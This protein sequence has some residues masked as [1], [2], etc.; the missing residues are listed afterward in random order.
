MSLTFTDMGMGEIAILN[1]TPCAN[2]DCI[3]VA[4]KPGAPL[5]SVGIFRANNTFEWLLEDLE[6]TGKDAEGAA[7]VR[8][9]PDG[10][11]QL[12][13]ISSHSVTGAGAAARPAYATIT[14]PG[15]SSSP[16]PSIP[17]GP[18]PIPPSA[19]DPRVD[20]IL[21]QLAS[22]QSAMQTII[23]T[24]SRMQNDIHAMQT[25]ID[26]V[27]AVE[28]QQALNAIWASFTD[29]QNSNYGMIVQRIQQI[30]QG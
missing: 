23:S 6:G 30:V 25:Q 10:S 22:M 16:N 27:K 11:K 15:A 1:I 20:T 13:I 12:V 4:K 2:G 3:I 29:P 18:L 14:W 19:H 28:W 26:T 7:F 5:N 17:P 21:Q 9:L 24:Q 8:E